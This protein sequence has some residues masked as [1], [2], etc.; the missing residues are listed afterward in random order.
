MYNEKFYTLYKVG[1]VLT[2]CAKEHGLNNKNREI[3]NSILFLITSTNNFNIKVKN[4]MNYSGLYTEQ[5]LFFAM[6]R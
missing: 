1:V 4:R 3:V 5:N 2:I 6:F